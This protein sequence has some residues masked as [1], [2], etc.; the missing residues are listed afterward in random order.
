[1][2]FSE[3]ERAGFIDA[4]VEF[5]MTRV[6]NTRTPEELIEAAKAILRGCEE[7]FRAA[8]THVSRI[9]GAVGP[10]KVEAFKTRAL[11]LL[12]VA[13]ADEFNKQ[14][15][16]IIRDF[17]KLKAWMEWWMRPSHATMLFSSQR[18]MEEHV[19]ES[20]PNTTNAE[21]AM[22][23]RFYS[24]AGRDHSFM[25][26]MKSLYKI[27]VDFERQ[28]EAVNSMYLNVFIHLR[29]NNFPEGIPIR[30]RRPE[31]WKVTAAEIGRTKQ[32]RAGDPAEKKRKKNDGRPPDTIKELL[33]PE[34]DTKAKPK[35]QPAQQDLGQFGPPSYPWKANS[36]WLDTSLELLFVC[37]MR[38]FDDFSTVFDT[39]PRSSGLH[40]FYST[41]NLRRLIADDVDNKTVT[42]A[43]GEQRD[44][45]RGLLSK[46][47]VI[48]NV[49]SSSSLMVRRRNCHIMV[50]LNFFLV[51]HGS[52][53]SSGHRCLTVNA[54]KQL[55][56]FVHRYLI[57][58][59]VLG[60]LRL[61]DHT[62]RLSSPGTTKNSMPA[63]IYMKHMV[64]ILQTISRTLSRSTSIL[65]QARFAGAQRTGY[66]FAQENES[67]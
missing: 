25:H 59:I 39:V 55:H 61:V 2:D 40:A 30:Y 27:A 29:T 51:R 21:E 34:K 38:N 52:T 65:L 57:S 58:T 7:H 49:T 44:K 11:G 63:A 32:T 13:S 18:L 50:Q 12:S 14:A 4:F 33:K 41:L 46:K 35:K 67:T 64:V 6:D 47:K 22:H 1:M 28:F 15:C 26:G 60:R 36:C 24:A 17:P 42:R 9:N 37:A 16:L 66:A 45:L 56:I 43:L 54:S 8:V 5:W 48:K 31:A 10:D 19:V 3:G 23:W 62:W 53:R 20:M